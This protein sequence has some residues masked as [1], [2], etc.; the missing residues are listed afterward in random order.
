M[1]GFTLREARP[2]DGDAILALMPRL[3]DFDVPE[4]RNPE[5]LWWH[6]AEMFRDWLAGRQRCLVHVAVDDAGELLGFTMVSLRP[7][8]LSD[9]PS[10]HLEAIALDPAAEG[11]GIAKALLNAAEESALAHG[12]QSMTLHVFAVNKRARRL[13]EKAGYDGE[14]MRYIKPLAG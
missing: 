14:L 13:Y 6:D 10:A 5:H 2:G 11:K 9:E 3:A 12:A 1:D 8:L 7:E 4:S